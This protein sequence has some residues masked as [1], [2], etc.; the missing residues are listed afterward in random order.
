MINKGLTSCTEF[1]MRSF[2]EGYVEFLFTVFLSMPVIGT[3]F[4][5][6]TVYT[7]TILKINVA[8][9]MKCNNIIMKTWPSDTNSINENLRQIFGLVF[10]G[11]FV[12]YSVALPTCLQKRTYNVVKYVN[13]H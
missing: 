13:I 4:V 5:S 3:M 8:I 10:S 1:D 6:F 7:T 2:Q 11:L 12:C 9:C